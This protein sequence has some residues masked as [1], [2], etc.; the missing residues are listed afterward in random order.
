LNARK[1]TSDV[2]PMLPLRGGL[3]K[4]GSLTGI[5]EVKPKTSIPYSIATALPSRM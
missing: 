3:D 5:D 1:A 2:K 4:T